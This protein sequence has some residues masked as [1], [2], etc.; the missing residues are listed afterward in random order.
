ME[1]AQSQ[2]RSAEKRA[3][4]DKSDT[5]TEAEAEESQEH[6]SHETRKGHMTNIYL[7]DSNEEAIVDFVKAHKELYDKI[8]EH[9]KDKARKDCLWEM[10]AN[11]HKLSVNVCN[12]CFLSRKGHVERN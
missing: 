3:K 12:M 9:F 7:M 2:G 4:T 5:E 1:E 8:N 11:S 10:F 6:H